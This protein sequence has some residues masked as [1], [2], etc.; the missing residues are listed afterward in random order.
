MNGMMAADLAVQG[1][2]LREGAAVCWPQFLSD[3]R[4]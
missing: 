3:G 1:F 4:D 2:D